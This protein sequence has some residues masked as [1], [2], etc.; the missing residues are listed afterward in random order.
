MKTNNNSTSDS[1]DCKTFSFTTEDGVKFEVNK[2]IKLFSKLFHNLLQDYGDDSKDK[3]LENIFSKDISL[4]LKFLEI[5]KYDENTL[6][7]EKPF[8]LNQLDEVKNNLFNNYPEFKTFYENLNSLTIIEYTKVA[9]FYDVPQLEDLINLKFYE[10]FSSNENIILFFGKE[11]I[12]DNNLLIDEEREKYLRDKY[13]I[14]S[15][16]QLENLGD[17][18]VEAML[19]KEFKI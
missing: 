6:K 16:K 8:I 15:E 19:K 3:K 5:I 4:L 17:E 12:N 10:V 18:Q 11:K 1:N 14:Y 2:K 9:D 13:I 7:I